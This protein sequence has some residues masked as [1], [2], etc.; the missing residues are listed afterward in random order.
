[1]DIIEKASDAINQGQLVAMPTETVYGLAANAEDEAACQ[2]IYQ[3]KKRP[4]ANPLI[5]HVS[6]FIEAQ[7][8]A[9]FN[10]DARLIA[11]LWPG[12]VTMVLPKKP[13]AKLADCVTAGLDTVAIRI[14]AHEIAL[15]LLKVCGRPLAAPSA[16]I[17]GMLSPTRQAH[18][19]N[20]FSSESMII[21]PDNHTSDGQSETGKYGLESTIIDLTTDEPTILRYGFI[22]PDLVE[23]ILGK[24]VAHGTKGSEGSEVKAPGMAFKHYSPVTKIL[25]NAE[26]VNKNQ[27]GLEFGASSL[28]NIYNSH[29]LNL[30]AKGDMIEAASNLFAMLHELDEYAIA[31]NISQIVVARVPLEG[32]GLAINDRLGRAAQ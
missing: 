11:S 27:I 4:S 15:K 9:V 26:Q 31:N 2:K 23:S 14:P 21:L 25:I 6:S 24:S 7:N 13:D 29:T 1:M 30:S 16:N 20:Y 17:S 5:V 10:Q 19:E 3:R 28:D 8:I 32:I 12:P 18:V 22:T